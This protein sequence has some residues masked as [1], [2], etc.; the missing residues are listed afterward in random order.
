MYLP[1]SFVELIKEPTHLRAGPGD[2]VHQRRTTLSI[3]CVKI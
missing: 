2:V 3:F 1:N